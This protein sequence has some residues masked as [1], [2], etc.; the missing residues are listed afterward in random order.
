MV[1]GVDPGWAM[2]MLPIALS[3][4]C[5]NI[6]ELRGREIFN[7]ALYD[8]PHVVREVIGFGGSMDELPMMLHDFALEMVWA[9]MVRLMGDALG[10]PVDAI[11]TEVERRPLESTIEVEGMG[12]FEQGTQGAFRFEVRGMHQG[13]ARF[14]IEH[15]TRIDDACAPEWPYPAEG[16]GCHQVLIKG[17]PDLSV[18]FH[19]EDHY[20][21]GAAGGG[22]ASA[23]N[24][25][26]NAIPGVASADAGIVTLLDLPWIDGAAQLSNGRFAMN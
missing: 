24:W 15:V 16:R 6:T 12:T 10:A 20:E 11:E 18:S 25:I 3:G 17:D 19:A 14:V 21:P 7:Y 22:N 23:A 5:S 1:S 26:V 9:P 2:D 8:Q 13:Q 4:A